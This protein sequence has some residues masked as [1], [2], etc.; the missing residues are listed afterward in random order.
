VGATN[1]LVGRE[2]EMALLEAVLDH[3]GRRRGA[4]VVLGEPGIG[5]TSL[6][7]AAAAH[8]RSLGYRVL[9]V[10]GVEP[11]AQLPFAG[12]QRLLQPVLGHV[13]ALP[14][15]QR[16]ALLTAF[17]IEDGAPPQPFLVALATLTLLTEAATESPL[18]LAVD[19]AQWLDGPSHDALTFVSRRLDHQPV[20]LVAT[21]RSGHPSP[22]LQVD[23]P[24]L[25]I[26]GLGEDASRTLLATHAPDIDVA[27][28]GVILREA[29]GNPLALVELPAAWR[30]TNGRGHDLVFVPLT[31]RLERAFA[32]RIDAL[33]RSTRDVLLVAAIDDED[34]LPETLLAAAA[35]AGEPVTVD[36]L[37]PASDARLL[38]FDAQGI[39]FR[40]PL[41][42]SGILQAESITRRQNAHAALAAVLTDQPYRCT[43]H[44]AQSLVG[45][46]DN[47]ADELETNH[48]I[49]LR[50]G[51]VA[52]AIW[53]LERSAQLTSDSAKRGRRL[54]L[55]AE[56]AFGLGRADLVDRLVG[57]ASR[58][59]LTELD[60]AR[61]AWISE[62]FNDGVPGDALR[63]T[64][65]C[66]IATR[67]AVAGD[68]GLA[69]NLLLGAALRCWWADAGAAAR[70]GVVAT[71]ERIGGEH[72]A[73]VVDDPRFVATL[74][75]AEP[76]AA[77]PR[78]SAL[79]AGV[80]LET[81]TDPDALRLYGQ[82][83]H[84]IGN[85]VRAIDFFARAE[86]RLREQGR[87]GLLSHVLTMQLF[88]RTEVGDWERAEAL[89]DEGTL[90]ARDTGQ[91]IWN[92]GTLSLVAILRGLR[93][94]YD[95]ALRLAARAEQLANG[96]RLTDLLACVQLAR[97]GAAVAAGRFAE[98]FAELHRLFD[99][100]DSAFHLTERYHGI[101]LLAEAAAHCGQ[102]DE[103]S[104]L[105]SAL[106]HETQSIPAPTLR[107]NLAYA[108]AILADDEHAEER[109]RAALG[110]D[111]MRWPWMRGRLELAFGAW[112]R[113]QRRV[114]ESR[115]PLRNAVTTLELIGATTWAERARAELR[116]TGEA[117]NE[118]DGLSLDV[119]S[120][121]ELQIAR[122]AAEGLSNREIGERLFLS[123]RTVGSH[124]YRIFPKLGIASRSQLAT[125]LG[126]GPATV[127]RRAMEGA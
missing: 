71:A 118:R 126:P 8:A 34:G 50:R 46:D 107:V 123:P 99:P 97:G 13:D 74:A 75:T 24:V 7:D 100:S 111:L 52:S 109:F 69:L 40:H 53:A 9:S 18:L 11:E 54:L 73:A 96:K 55:A 80:V 30:S 116:A 28:R 81:V 95:E 85:P 76:V 38:T 27:T 67:S 43:W 106:E 44:R 47:V 57:A 103:A 33:P 39:R 29:M 89:A 14:S 6:L 104:S 12:L 22:L 77:A 90:V 45:V 61:M 119:L 1:S 122:L 26:E 87:L 91:E 20:V 92:D 17:S 102:G 112:L 49:A 105:L 98:G 58:E 23:V 35:L 37:D 117:V 32:A 94:D 72:G 15:A 60:R 108:R 93:G 127:G 3:D 66:E 62:I 2:S 113:R 21:I 88:N 110:Q 121:Q 78:V 4:L 31:A 70:A 65:L 19:D 86:S 10:G 5:K 64:E 68:L 56:L 59:E 125:R 48:R 79:L 101:A 41:V 124:L 83:A 16:G 63:V 42:R 25:A 51:S 114:A 84:A 82:A 120:P 115:L 36:A